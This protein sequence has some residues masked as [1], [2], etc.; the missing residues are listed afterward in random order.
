MYC[1]YSIFMIWNTKIKHLYKMYIGASWWFSFLQCRFPEVSTSWSWRSGCESKLNEPKQIQKRYK[2][3]NLAQC[4]NPGTVILCNW[5][6]QIFAEVSSYRWDTISVI[7]PICVSVTL[8]QYKDFTAS[9]VHQ[10]YL[11][12]SASTSMHRRQSWC[13][14]CVVAIRI[15]WTG[16]HMSSY[17]TVVVVV[18]LQFESVTFSRK[19][20]VFPQW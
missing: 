8:F 9:S 19:S 2:K 20:S 12:I 4:W 14:R 1:M 11:V 17:P 6:C 15:L 5:F 18:V 3:V 13:V 10:S 16:K 7:V